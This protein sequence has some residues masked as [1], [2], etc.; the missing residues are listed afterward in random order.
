MGFRCRQQRVKSWAGA[1][2]RRFPAYSDGRM[3]RVVLN[4]PPLESA[5]TAA[6][7][8]EALATRMLDAFGAATDEAGRVDYS[9]LRGS[10]ELGAAIEAA[11]GLATVRLDTLTARGVTL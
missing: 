2:W 8:A 11:R 10:T 3:G 6:A 5:S 7:Q 9:K 1:R 4:D